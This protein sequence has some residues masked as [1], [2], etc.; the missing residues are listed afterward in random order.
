[1]RCFSNFTKRY[2]VYKDYYSVYIKKLVNKD[3]FIRDD[4][5]S[6]IIF[7][8]FDRLYKKAIP[9]GDYFK[10]LS[11]SP[12]NEQGEILIP[13]D[14]YIIG[15]HTTIKIVENIGNKLKMSGFEKNELHF[16]VYLGASPRFNK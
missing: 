8:A 12:R 2:S 11:T 9:K 4:E 16:N 15:E 14:D 3:Y 13:Y 10:L 1:M 5:M 7:V 6:S